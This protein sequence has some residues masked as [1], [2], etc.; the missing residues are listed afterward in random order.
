MM[1]V[2]NTKMNVM[3]GINT[4][5]LNYFVTALPEEK[6]EVQYGRAI[7]GNANDKIAKPA[8]MRHWNE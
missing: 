2:I 7:R 6:V 4:G 1:K 5:L 8:Y 3:K